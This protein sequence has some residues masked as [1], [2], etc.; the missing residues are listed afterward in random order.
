MIPFAI[1][2]FA[3][4][5]L[6]LVGLFA[7][8]ALGGYF[9]AERRARTRERELVRQLSEADQALAQAHASDKGWERSALEAAARQAFAERFG[10]AGFEALHLVQVIDRPGTDA[11]QAVFRVQTPDGEHRITLGRTNGV[12]GP[13]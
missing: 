5:L 6:V 1:S 9:A 7:L 10:D 3:L 2:T 13:A 11:D 4:V 12:W 8:L